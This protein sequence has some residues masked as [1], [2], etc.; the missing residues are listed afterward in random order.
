V[1]R[2]GSLWE[3]R[4]LEQSD[5]PAASLGAAL[6]H[7][8]DALD[9][10]QESFGSGVLFTLVVNGVL[11][12]TF[13]LLLAGSISQAHQPTLLLAI[14]A[15]LSSLISAASK[16]LVDDLHATYSKKTMY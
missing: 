13:L 12:R 8:W 10:D 2:W 7:W 6:G 4:S 1:D 11:K 5:L 14:L 16:S 9:R 15:G 3:W